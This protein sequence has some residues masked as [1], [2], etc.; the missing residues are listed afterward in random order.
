LLQGRGENRRPRTR[1]VAMTDMPAPHDLISPRDAHP[2][3][4]RFL[5]AALPAVI[6]AGLVLTVFGGFALDRL[7]ESPLA[8]LGM[9]ACGAIALLFVAFF[10]DRREARRE[11]AERPAEPILGPAE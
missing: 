7:P 2:G 1:I 9:V 4:R 8:R 6:Y 3:W 10:L 5:L 11:A